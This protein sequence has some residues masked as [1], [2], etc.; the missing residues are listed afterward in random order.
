MFRSL[1]LLPLFLATLAAASDQPVRVWTDEKGETLRGRLESF[2]GTTAVIRPSVG[3]AV[4][5]P[6]EKLSRGDQRYLKRKLAADPTLAGPTRS[7]DEPAGP[8]GGP[9]GPASG[10]GPAEPPEAARS[11]SGAT[12]LP[13]AGESGDWRPTE[14]EVPHAELNLPEATEANVLTFDG[15][16]ERTIAAGNAAFN[17]VTGAMTVA[18]KSSRR[19]PTFTQTTKVIQVDL[20]DGSEVGRVELPAEWHPQ[21]TDGRRSLL[22]RM[23]TVADARNRVELWEWFDRSP[24]RTVFVNCF[25]GHK[26]H[27]DRVEWATV[28]SDGRLAV[29]NGRAMRLIR[30]SEDGR[31]A[32]VTHEF[33]TETHCTPGVDP[34]G[35][36][37]AV[38]GVSAVSL[39]DADADAVVGTRSVE[40][41]LAQGRVAVSNDGRRLLAATRQALD[42]FDVADG[43]FVTR[44][45]LD[46]PYL[47]KGGLD[48]LGGDRYL[49]AFAIV[50]AAAK[51]ELWD[52]TGAQTVA[53]SGAN[54]V[55]FADD[56]ITQPK[57]SAVAVVDSGRDA[58][59]KAVEA[60]KKDADAF[61]LRPGIEVSVRVD[62]VDDAEAA[63][64]IAAHLRE[65][66]EDRSFRVVEGAPVTIVGSVRR[67]EREERVFRGLLGAGR[68]ETVTT[69]P[70][71]A[72]LRVLAGGE[73]AWQK[74]VSSLPTLLRM[75][76]EESVADAVR[77]HEVPNPE[78]LLKL[79]PPEYLVSPAYRRNR[80]GESRVTSQ[81]L[82]PQARR[83][84][85][86]GPAA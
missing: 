35:R 16:D 79:T 40:G 22:I 46:E 24:K 36:L 20:T 38:P 62:G 84:R 14:I 51:R 39:F 30:L 80:L 34:S 1:L 50:D 57:K 63:D 75:K 78:A 67:A 42:V 52:H 68:T 64:S 54:L 8:E 23:R 10:D 2:D 59:E 3:E 85:R 53:A 12:F 9:A 60:A 71:E 29:S 15:R 76:A 25:E 5:V 69:Q 81:G 45:P 66:A 4:T 48:W 55:F 32:S 37:L 73:T 56:F 86:G 41:T 49:V 33:D 19:E 6:A 13:V 47:K 70:Y 7:P 18:F 11:V 61:T 26:S 58:V 31:S 72:T 77:R 21:W 82:R 65:S 43:S 44:V 28:L 83:V 74:S 17:A 27:Y